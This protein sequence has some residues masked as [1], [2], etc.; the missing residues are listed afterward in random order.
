MKF[1]KGSFAI[2][3][4][5]RISLGLML[6]VLSVLGGSYVVGLVPSRT[7]EVNLRRLEMAKTLAIQ[8]SAAVENSEPEHV[9]ALA[10]SITG[11]LREVKSI[12][13]RRDTKLVFTTPHH[14]ADWRDSG[15]SS[16]GG[17]L[18]RI[19]V[20]IFDG[21]K[22]WGQLELTFISEPTSLRNGTAG[23]IIFFAA[24]SLLGFMLFMRR[25]LRV[26]DP[27]Q[28]IPERVRSMLNTLAEG[29]IITDSSGQIMLA[30]KSFADIVGAPAEKLLG[31]NVSAM[32]WITK[33]DDKSKLPWADL[34]GEV[35]C[36]GVIVNLNI[37]A[38]ERS[39]AVNASSILGERGHTR[40][41]LITFDDITKVEQKN[42]QLVEMLRQLG[43]AQERVQK[44]NEE[45]SRL[46]ARDVLTGCLN[47]RSFH[48][49]VATLFALS[50]RERS[51]L[52][53]IMVD[54]DHFKSIH[55]NY[56]HSRGDD[57]LREV[58]RILREAVRASDVVCRY[59]GEEFCVLLPSTSLDAAGAVAEKLRSAISASQIAELS[60]T[61]SLGMSCTSLQAESPQ[62]LVDQADEALYDSKRAGRNRVTRFDRLDPDVRAEFLEKRQE[63]PGDEEHIPVHAVKCLLSAL[64][65]RDP[66]TA[67]HSRRV[68]DLCVKAGTLWLE[69]KD[70]FI[71]ETAA[72]LHDI[73]KVGVPDAILLKPGA[74]TEDEWTIMRRHDNI[75][76]QI[77]QTSFNCER[78]T[79]IIA[80]HHARHD[81]SN[82]SSDGE[83][84]DAVP[85]CARLLAIADAYDAM[86]SH[87]CY[88]PAR[89][90]E[91]AVNE[92]R[93]CAGTQFDPLL[94]Q[95][96]INVVTASSTASDT[97]S[98]Q[99]VH[100]LRLGMEAEMLATAL[101]KEDLEAVHALADHLGAAARA[102][103]S[104]Q[105]AQRCV[106]IS[107]CVDAAADVEGLLQ[108]VR[109]LLNEV[110]TQSSQAIAASQANQPN[111]TP[112]TSHAR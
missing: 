11:S 62:K 14:E 91:E 36:R 79:A 85:L 71:L 51:P 26:L 65:F 58:G 89:S 47:R 16:R 9:R 31:T 30:N 94:V 44:Q 13:L 82:L 41:C 101:L 37:G 77:V 5:T 48:E 29:A 10:G 81:Q 105:I 78:L 93:Q 110:T 1:G 108:Q 67:E 111:A 83:A 52:S 32:P 61:A 53:T 49:Q 57:V 87:R 8:F 27:S 60:I 7:T 92:L 35:R 6:I 33:A 46:A 19:K 76:V 112:A 98:Q 103:G 104:E 73:G 63:L 20:P 95:H 99:L 38:G 70:L 34:T 2:G 55:D 97:K 17:S 4:P 72:L 88:R 3:N 102:L 84:G 24:S 80:R 22:E 43:E 109:E 106:S 21:A 75:G 90:A 86:V 18:Q 28:V 59:G 66:Q 100:T 56:G 23:L 39:L 40:G 54:L 74:L 25:T 50:K 107:S 68:A 96:F 45:L 69:P 64:S 42:Q 12:G 15:G